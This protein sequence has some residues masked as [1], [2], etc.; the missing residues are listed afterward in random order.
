MCKVIRKVSMAIFILDLVQ[1]DLYTYFY[2]VR[3]LNVRRGVQKIALIGLEWTK[4]FE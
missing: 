4:L 2:R 3:K 1:K